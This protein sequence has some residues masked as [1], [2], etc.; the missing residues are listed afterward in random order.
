MSPTSSAD[1]VSARPGKESRQ[2][3]RHPLEQHA[4]FHTEGVRPVTLHIQHAPFATGQNFP[5]ADLVI[6]QSSATAAPIRDA[7]ATTMSAPYGLASCIQRCGSHPAAVNTPAV[8]TSQNS[9]NG[10][11]TFQPSRISWS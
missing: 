1:D 6:G 7:S 10:R 5:A 4:I 8:S 11:N 3:I 2:F 9:E